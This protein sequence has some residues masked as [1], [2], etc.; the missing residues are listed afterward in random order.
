MSKSIDRGIKFAKNAAIMSG[1]PHHKV[2]AAIFAGRRLISLGWN[3]KKTHPDS[4]TRHQ[5]HHAEFAALIGNYKYDL[6]GAV[7]YVTRITPGGVLSMS[8]PCEHCQEVIRA[9][10]IRKVFYTN[11]AGDVEKLCL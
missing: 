10:G 7:I 2:G 4:K 1:A 9:S 5:A 11:H 6:V 8:K 3:S